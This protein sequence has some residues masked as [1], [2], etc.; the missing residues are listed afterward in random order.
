MAGT[1][2]TCRTPGC[3]RQFTP[4]RGTRRVY[5]Y[6]CRP[7]RA[8]SGV[9]SMSAP[10]LEPA[11]R[12]D[13]PTAL[14]VRAELERAEQAGTVTAAVALR[15]ATALDDPG[16]AAAQV[17]SMSAKLLQVMEPLARMGAQV[18]DEVDEFTRRLA[19]KRASA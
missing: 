16:L 12:I 4:R 14:A 2:R 7:E 15:L 17:A 18:P 9:E 1:R 19:E 11:G 13:G 6:E 3:R 5:C 8:A 10:A